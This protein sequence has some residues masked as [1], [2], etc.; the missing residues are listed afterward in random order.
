MVVI[1]ILF[2][3]ALTSF[4]EGDHEAD[5]M[6]MDSPVVVPNDEDG[7]QPSPQSMGA[8]QSLLAQTTREPSIA[9][10]P[11]GESAKPVPR[12]GKIRKITE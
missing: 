6:G 8:L 7:S 3:L 1:S 10:K 2:Q 4:Y 9:K 5:D 11:K 12:Y